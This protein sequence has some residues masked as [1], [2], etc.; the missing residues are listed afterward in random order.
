M[1]MSQ[2]LPIRQHIPLEFTAETETPT[3][4]PKKKKNEKK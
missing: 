1:V 2:A 4:G 3:L